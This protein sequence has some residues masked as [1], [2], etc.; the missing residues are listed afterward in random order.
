M[1]ILPSLFTSVF[2]SCKLII[3]LLHFLNMKEIIFYKTVSE[4]CPVE[5]FLDSLTGKQ[6]QKVIWVLRLIRELETIPG[7][8]F[9][10]L[11]NTD[12]IWEARIQVGN[13]TFRILGFFDG[14]DLIVMNHAFIKKTQKTPLNEIVIAEKRK[15]EYFE[16]KE[17]G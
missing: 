7:N 14:T 11:K 12:D 17:N 8:Y 9:K 3:K 15:K 4:K 13:N 16:R 5:E 1:P 6:A 10:K 2:L